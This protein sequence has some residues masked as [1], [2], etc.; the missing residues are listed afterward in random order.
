[1]M[2]SVII[3]FAIGEPLLAFADRAIAPY[4]G[5]ADIGKELL[6]GSSYAVAGVILLGVQTREHQA[7]SASERQVSVWQDIREGLQYLRRNREV[8]AAL[9]QLI[10]L[11]SIFAALAVLAVRLAEVMPGITSSQFGFL[12][13][14]GGVGMGLG[15]LIVGQLGHRIA[16]DRLSLYGSLCFG[17]SLAALSLV[18]QQLLATLL[19]LVALGASAAIVGVPLQTTIQEQTPEAMRGKVFGLQNNAV[20]IALS[21]PLALAG[22]AEAA[23]GLQIVLLSL[24]GTAI[25]TGIFT[26]SLAR[27]KETHPKLE[28]LKK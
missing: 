19:I 21:L 25:A 17:L 26:W 11:F 5:V 15:A 16:R 13:A 4:A 9:I 2:A 7:Q 18:T 14:A 28:G 24:G 6:V 22:I 3:G 10:V 8:R 12:L 23:L 1:M 20:N 27:H